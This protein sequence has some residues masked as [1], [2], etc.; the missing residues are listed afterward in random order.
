MSAKVCCCGH[1]TWEHRTI[2]GS[3]RRCGAGCPKFHR[4]GEGHG[5]AF[6]I[7]SVVVILLGLVALWKL[8]HLHYNAPYSCIGTAEACRNVEEAVLQGSLPQ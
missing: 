3:C 5:R 8:T 2:D 7:T 6:E 4:V 1:M